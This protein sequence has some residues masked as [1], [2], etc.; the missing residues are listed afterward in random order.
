M[1][2]EAAKEGGSSQISGIEQGSGGLLRRPEDGKFAPGNR[3]GGRK[4][5]AVEKAYLD[6]VK[7]ALPPEAIADL[8]E[9]ALELA[10]DTRSW[11]GMAEIITIALQYGAGKPTQKVVSS[12]GNLETLLAALADDKPLLPDAAGEIACDKN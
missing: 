6:A 12:D 10:R 3:S 9:E 8:L 7:Q 5:K 4:P 11:R 2:E 1:G